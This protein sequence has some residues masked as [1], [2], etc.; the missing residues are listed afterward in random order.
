M[1]NYNPI[2][3][4]ISKPIQTQWDLL[5]KN[6][7]SLIHLNHINSLAQSLLST[8]VCSILFLLSFLFVFWLLIHRLWLGL[9]INK[10]QLFVAI[11]G[12]VYDVTRNKAKYSNGENYSVFIGKDASLLLA[13]SSLDN[14]ADREYVQ[15]AKPRETIF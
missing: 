1:E 11:K 2:P 6:Q 14:S 3:F 7:F 8:M 12:V 9:G 5:Q 15:K 4:T 10:P 13:M